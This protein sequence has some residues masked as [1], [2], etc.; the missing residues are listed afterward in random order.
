M[1][2]PKLYQFA[3]LIVIVGMLLGVGI[4]ALDKFGVAA[5]E[6]A[7]ITESVAIVS[8]VGASANDDTTDLLAF[9]N[10]TNTW[11]VDVDVNLTAAGV[12]TTR[13][14]VSDGTYTMNYTY[15]KDTAATTATTNTNTE[16][17]TIA[18]TWIG[19]IVTIFVL[20]IIITLV[21]SS[22]SFKPR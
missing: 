10:S 15:D 12:V 3:L 2:L 14:N 9:Y 20:A 22:F 7:T 5:K 21:I 11:V 8:K 19:L 4:L 18:S 1:E 6:E 13:A 17:G 16:L